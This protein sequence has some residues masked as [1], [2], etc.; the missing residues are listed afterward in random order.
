[1]QRLTII[2]VFQLFVSLRQK[3]KKKETHSRNLRQY[4]FLPRFPP[5][6]ILNTKSRC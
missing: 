6:Y 3:K 4:R 1:M 2:Y 5:F